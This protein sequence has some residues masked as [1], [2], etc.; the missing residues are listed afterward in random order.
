MHYIYTRQV[1]YISIFQSTKQELF[2]RVALKYIYKAL[3]VYTS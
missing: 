1:Y 3:I 2:E